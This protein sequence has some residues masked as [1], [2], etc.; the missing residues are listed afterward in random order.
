M[1]RRESGESIV[2]LFGGGW[3]DAEFKPFIHSLDDMPYVPGAR[4]TKLT[5]QS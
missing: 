2:I 1:P 4:Y 3:K 5:R